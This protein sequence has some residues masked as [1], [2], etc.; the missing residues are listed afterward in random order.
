M[1]GAKRSWVYPARITGYFQKVHRVSGTILIFI[2][3]AIPWVRIA[4]VPLLMIDIPDRRLF[5]LGMVYTP[6]DSLLLFLFAITAVFTL[7][8]FTALY[9][10]LWCGFGCPQTVFLEEFVRRI[11]HRLEG[12]RGQRRRRDEG[13]WTAEKVRIKAMKW[14]IFMVLSL[15][16][17]FSVAGY[18]D[19]AYEIWSGKAAPATYVLALALATVLYLDFAWFREQFCIY[20]CPYA[21]MQGVMVDEHSVVIG[22][23][24]PRG[25]PRLSKAVLKAGTPRSELGDC[26]GCDRCVAVCPTGIDIRDGFQ[27]E[28]ISCARCI[29]AC[30]EV[31]GRQDKPSLVRFGGQAELEG[32]GERKKWR[33]RPIVYGTINTVAALTA[34]FI[35]VQRPA[36]DLAIEPVRNAE[37]M[38]T[39]SGEVRERF[40]VRAFNNSMLERGID[41]SVEGIEGARLAI[42]GGGLHL[43][44]AGRDSVELFVVAPRASLNSGPTPF[45]L[46]GSSD[47]EIIRREA[48]FH[49]F[50]RTQH[51]SLAN[52]RIPA[53]R[54]SS[55]GEHTHTLAGAESR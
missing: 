26:V 39:A 37:A 1:I 11:E 32:K 29:D 6:R 2:L 8:F 12:N 52:P 22:Y 25:E 43:D 20:L 24:A 40:A 54:S 55:R 15:L 42:P 18:F 44:P 35:V 17:A 48:T 21:R 3:C 50:E 51:A 30:T 41:L 28:C 36:F 45:T 46:V 7:S 4:G 19:S 10:R 9:G 33:F 13:P 53:A 16:L 5:L 38:T 31:L 23:E 49:Y 14:S 47:G 27:L 34:L